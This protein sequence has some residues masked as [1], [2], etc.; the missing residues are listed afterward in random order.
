[1]RQILTLTLIALLLTGLFALSPLR[2]VSAHPGFSLPRQDSPTA[3]SPEGETPTTA[4]APTP[5]DIINAVNNLR[6]S[7]GLNALT[8]HPVLAQV[9]QE[10]AN[11]LAASDGSIGHERPCGLTLGQQLLQMGYPLSG[12]LSLDGYRS[13]NWVAA[14][15]TEQAISFWLGDDLHT[16]TMLS[17]HRS[18]IGAAVAVGDQIY[19]A[20][21]TAL[22]T[23]SGNMQYEA[24][25]ILTGI[26]MTR[27]ACIGEATQYAEY[28]NLP[29]YSIPVIKNTA[30]PDGDVIHEVKYG[31]ALWSI[32]IQYGTTMQQIRRLNNL[33]TDTLQPGQKL[34]VMNAATQPAPGEAA[35]AT[36]P[37]AADYAFIVTPV[38]TVTPTATVVTQTASSGDFV[39]QNGMVIMILGISFVVLL[40][41]FGVL[42]RRK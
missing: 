40:A 11:A 12:A 13:E 22:R 30:L 15:T 41:G 16:N 9:A 10:Q 26:P 2:A 35:P 7:H 42:G 37:A 39:K 4:S 33:Y 3:T 32:A 29:Q 5:A 18:D 1:M 31:Q 19:V 23:E 21:E 25:G 17:E 34:I 14:S 28:S 38:I 27:T 36:A 20:L 8:V 24:G 6:L